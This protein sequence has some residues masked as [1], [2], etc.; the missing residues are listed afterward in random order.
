MATEVASE[1]TL[2]G[3]NP[4]GGSSG[5]SSFLSIYNRVES[6]IGYYFTRFY[7]IVIILWSLI[8]IGSFFTKESRDE[9]WIATLYIFNQYDWSFIYAFFPGFTSVTLDNFISYSYVAAYCLVAFLLFLAWQYPISEYIDDQEGDEAEKEKSTDKGDDSFLLKV[10]RIFFRKQV[11]PV[12]L[13]TNYVMFFGFIFS[14]VFLSKFLILSAYFEAARI[15]NIENFFL[16]L[17]FPFASIFLLTNVLGIVYNVLVLLFFNII[18]LSLSFGIDEVLYTVLNLIYVFL[19]TGGFIYQFYRGRNI[20][21]VVDSLSETSERLETTSKDLL[22]IQSENQTI[23]DYMSD[24]MVLLNDKFYF[25]STYSKGFNDIFGLG[26]SMQGKNFLGFLDD[27]LKIDD[28]K[29]TYVRRYFELLL[30]GGLSGDMQAKANPI[31]KIKL[32]VD[33]K[34]KWLNFKFTLVNLG[35]GVKEILVQIIDSTDEDNLRIRVQQEEE[36]KNT[37]I[38]LISELI[39]SEKSLVNEF[40]VDLVKQ[41]REI[42]QKLKNSNDIKDTLKE[43]FQVLHSLKGRASVLKLKLL[44]TSIHKVEDELSKNLE[45]EKFE[46][47]D[48]INIVYKISSLMNEAKYAVDLAKKIGIDNN[49]EKSSSDLFKRNDSDKDRSVVDLNFFISETLKTTNLKQRKGFSL[50]TNFDEKVFNKLNHVSKEAI[51]NIAIQLIKNSSSHGFKKED[52]TNES[53]S[54]FISLKNDLEKKEKV[55]LYKDNGQGVNLTE[56]RDKLIL[57]NIVKPGEELVEKDLV[58]KIFLDQIST[59]SSEEVDMDSGRGIGMSL[60]KSN[61]EKN[62]AG[63]LEIISFKD[64]FEIEIRF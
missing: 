33:G 30:K 62:L 14:L 22:K 57:K 10:V 45:G 51:I 7:L 29:V 20:K 36:R 25:L 15:A 56:L 3:N 19:F 11:Q 35:D 55:F 52:S 40:L 39:Q 49:Q 47:G 18:A 61:V 13:Y 34:N 50:K 60:I 44:S 42:N 64:G 58:N 48:S 27:V 63:K 6:Q 31:E 2:T 12:V 37:E 9:L 5:S 26:T 24:G 28:Q 41:L 59:K 38:V 53:P 43:V 46:L 1:N 21:Q 54:I 4:E 16:I 32:E 8:E 23:M 17:I